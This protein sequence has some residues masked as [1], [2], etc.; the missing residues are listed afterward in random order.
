MRLRTTQLPAVSVKS[1]QTYNSIYTSIKHTNCKH[2][3]QVTKDVPFSSCSDL[4]KLPYK[5]KINATNICAT[6]RL[7]N[8]NHHLCRFQTKTP[9]YAYRFL[10]T[11]SEI[12][13]KVIKEKAHIDKTTEEFSKNI[14]RFDKTVEIYK[15]AVSI[16]LAGG[17]EKSIERHVKRH[18]KMVITDRLKSLFDDGYLE[19]SLIGGIGMEYGHIPRANAL[20]GNMAFEIKLIFF[21]H[22]FLLTEV[23]I[24][25]KC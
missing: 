13:F 1:Y 17:G 24:K 25:M 3:L 14:S 20:T 23:K 7:W 4:K 12:P 16:S 19:L 21:L 15:Q 5:I 6:H 22:Y 11:C 9:I 8:G 2:H 18:G 10:S